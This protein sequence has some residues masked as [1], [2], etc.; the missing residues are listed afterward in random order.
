MPDPHLQELADR[1]TDRFHR[2][3]ELRKEGDKRT[4]ERDKFYA[5]QDSGAESLQPLPSEARPVKDPEVVFHR[6]TL[7]RTT[8]D[9]REEIVRG[10]GDRRGSRWQW[11]PLYK[12]CDLVSVYGELALMKEKGRLRALPTEADPIRR[13][14]P[15]CP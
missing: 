13:C 4:K 10:I 14:K 1:F 15:T 7:R 3:P 12:G 8:A 11:A 2:L 6:L 9:G 5:N